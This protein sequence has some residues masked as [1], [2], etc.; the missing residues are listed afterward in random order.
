[1]EVMRWEKCVNG[2]K[3]REEITNWHLVSAE[4]ILLEVWQR[5]GENR[6]MVGGSKKLPKLP[7]S[8]IW[9]NLNNRN[10]PLKKA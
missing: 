9:K 10:R 6:F 4:I 1:M 5:L 2:K 3:L 8:P 7:A